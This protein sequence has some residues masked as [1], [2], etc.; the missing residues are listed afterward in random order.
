MRE[1]AQLLGGTL[2]AGE[3][4]GGWH[5]ELRLPPPGVHS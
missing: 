4:D 2:T 3:S 5:V 1:R